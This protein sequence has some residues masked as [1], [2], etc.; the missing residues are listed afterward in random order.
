MP[1][2]SVYGFWY[3]QEGETPGHSL[4][5][6]AG[7]SGPDVTPQQIEDELVRIDGDLAGVVSALAGVETLARQAVVLDEIDA[8]G[9]STDASFS[10]A[11]HGYRHLAIAWVGAHTEEDSSYVSLNLRINGD[12]GDVYQ[13]QRISFAANSGAWSDELV[14]SNSG[15]FSVLRVGLVGNGTRGSGLVWIPA[16]DVTNV[17]SCWGIAAAIRSSNATVC[18]AGGRYNNPVAVNSLQLWPSGST[19]GSLSRLTLLGWRP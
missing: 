6:D 12:N 5:P 4:T 1:Q 18:I 16:A 13:S 9:L 15:T 7:P 14:I 10:I 2:T 11:G 19:W 3:E 8:A 17:R